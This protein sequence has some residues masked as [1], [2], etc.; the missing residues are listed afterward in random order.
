MDGL[1]ILSQRMSEVNSRVRGN[2]VPNRG[3]AKL[4]FIE[5]FILLDIVLQAAA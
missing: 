4:A 2:Q 1:E 3:G 5:A